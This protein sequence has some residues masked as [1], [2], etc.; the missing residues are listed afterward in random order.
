MELQ[1]KLDFQDNP[2]LNINL[3][4]NFIININISIHLI[5]VQIDNYTV[6]FKYL[7]YNQR[8]LNERPCYM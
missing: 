6:N 1:S 4:I 7:L 3:N 2:L 5:I 8:Y